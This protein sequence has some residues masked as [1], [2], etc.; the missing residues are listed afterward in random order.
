MTNEQ[1]IAKAKQLTM[2]DIDQ[3]VDKIDDAVKKWHLE[4][5]STPCCEEITSILNE[6][7]ET[8]ALALEGEITPVSEEDRMESAFGS[9]AQEE[10]NKTW[11][12]AAD[13]LRAQK[14]NQ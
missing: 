3:V 4:Y 8:Q 7:L 11:Q 14:I 12:Q 10:V 2:K 13:Y 6:Y 5:L 1:K 9:L